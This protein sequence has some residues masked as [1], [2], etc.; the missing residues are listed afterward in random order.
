MNIKRVVFGIMGFVILAS[1]LY[2]Q[3]QTTIIQGGRF[4]LKEVTFTGY[5]DIDKSTYTIKGVFKIDTETGR[6][7]EL[8]A[9]T[10][11]GGEEEMGFYEI[12]RYD[13]VTNGQDKLIDF[14]DLLKEEKPT[15][16][17]KK[18]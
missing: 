18:K 4:Q 2:A 3:E 12:K 9:R 10:K 15:Q 16:E 8:E 6:V 17:D 5:N 11:E 13:L 14:S 7:W 1:M